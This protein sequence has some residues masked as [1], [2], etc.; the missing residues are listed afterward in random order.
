MVIGKL[1]NLPVNRVNSERGAGVTKTI[2]RDQLLPIGYL[3]RFSVPAEKKQQHRKPVTRAEEEK[4]DNESLQQN[5]EEFQEGWEEK[6]NNYLPPD[7][8]AFPRTLQQEA[9]R[10]GCLTQL[11]I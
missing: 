9:E 7:I 10:R 2:Y 11:S 6:S 4:Y 1:P 8:G 3:V 5:S